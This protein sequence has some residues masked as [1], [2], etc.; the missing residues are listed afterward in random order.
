MSV[1]RF[2]NKMKSTGLKMHPRRVPTLQRKNS[3][4]CSLICTHE[5]NLQYID[6]NTFSNLPSITLSAKHVNNFAG[7]IVSNAFAK[8]PYRQ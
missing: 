8:S 3:V 6:L 7:S 1:M 5:C 2:T 4:Q